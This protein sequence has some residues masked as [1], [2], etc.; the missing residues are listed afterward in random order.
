M[1]LSPLVSTMHARCVKISMRIILLELVLAFMKSQWKMNKDCIMVLKEVLKHLL[2]CYCF[3]FKIVTECG[4]FCRIKPFEDFFCDFF[5][6]M[7]KTRRNTSHLCFFRNRSRSW[8][9][10]SD[11]KGLFLDSCFFTT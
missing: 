9:R 5:M 4:P 8:L 11:S 1:N 2:A 10:F 3:L 6:I 7:G